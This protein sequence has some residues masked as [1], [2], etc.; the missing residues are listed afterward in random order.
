MGVWGCGG[1]VGVLHGIIALLPLLCQ[2]FLLITYLLLSCTEGIPD[3]GSYPQLCSTII[4][5]LL[6]F[7][8]IMT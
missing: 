6:L 3:M 2:Y 4:V 1:G 8:F 5:L 7:F